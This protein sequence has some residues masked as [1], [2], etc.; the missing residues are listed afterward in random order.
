M[1]PELKKWIAGAESWH[2]Y[3]DF[4]LQSESARY[5]FL[6]RTEDYYINLVG[7]VFK[8]L[9]ED[10]ISVAD[11]ES[12]RVLARALEIF[13]LKHTRSSFSG[14]D[15]RE[16]VLISAAMYRVAGYPASSTFLLNQYKNSDFQI[17]TDQLL[18]RLLS[19]DLSGSIDDLSSK[20]KEYIF[21]GD[22]SALQSLRHEIE[23]RF[24]GVGR[25]DPKSFLSLKLC[26]VLLCALEKDCIW[27]ILRAS[28]ALTEE[29]ISKFITGN[30]L[31]RSNPVWS[32]F[33][34]QITA[35]ESGVL[36]PQGAYALQMPTSAGKTALAEVII[37]SEGVRESRGKIIFLAP[38]RSLATELKNSFA[39][40]LRS[41]GIKVEVLYGD[42]LLCSSRIARISE[43]DLIISTPEKF[44]ALAG[45]LPTLFE[46]I[47]LAICDE[48]HL[49]DEGKR[50][51]HYELLLAR[52]K[53]NQEANVIFLSAVVPNID[54]INQWLGGDDDSVIKSGYKPT[55][56][57]YGFLRE[58][59]TRESFQL[60]MNPLDEYPQKYVLFDFLVEPELFPMNRNRTRPRNGWP[61]AVCS[62]AAAIKATSSGP[63][64]LFTPTIFDNQGVLVLARKCLQLLESHDLDIKGFTFERLDNESKISEYLK[65]VFGIDYLLVQLSFFGV[66][67]HCGILPQDVR[68][69]IEESLRENGIRLIICTKTLAEGVNL[70]IRTLLIH[71]LWITRGEND[72]RALRV[73][74]IKNIV[75]RAGRA[76]KEVKGTII[77]TNRRSE[78]VLL[79][80]I[81]G[82]AGESV[83][84]FLLK[85]VK[86]I[87]TAAGNDA[88]TQESAITKLSSD[89]VDALDLAILNMLSENADDEE[90]EN[91]ISKLIENSFANAQCTESQQE[92]L[93]RLFAVRKSAI[94][95]TFSDGSFAALK[96][97]GVGPNLYGDILFALDVNDERWTTA[98]DDFGGDI[99]D[100]LKHNVEQ[101]AAWHA[102]IERVLTKYPWITADHYWSII[103]GW[104][105]GE[106]YQTLATILNDDTPIKI[107]DV[108]H[109]LGDESVYKLKI[110]LDAIVNVA[111]HSLEQRNL[112]IAPNLKLFSVA[113]TFGLPSA[114][115]AHLANMGF[116]ERLSNLELGNFL[117]ENHQAFS[118]SLDQ[119]TV[120]AAVL[121]YDEDLVDRLR[122]K[123]PLLSLEKMR[124]GIESVKDDLF[125]ASLCT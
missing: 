66:A 72:R 18:Y 52:L 114:M 107:D 105:R 3:K 45:R 46:E 53:S 64:A 35:I 29:Q 79:S 88:D 108:L 80:V 31:K 24:D 86:A 91:T 16:N 117:K 26:S 76:G 36:N 95:Q 23:V 121:F 32:F 13:S 40:R 27:T 33:P 112:V 102:E 38:Y 4:D 78:N 9:S 17:D 37:Y 96:K 47:S 75:G 99:F 63:T 82:D 92:V 69:I 50:G 2:S 116:G 8:I 10:E 93:T 14:I 15:T 98:S 51:L 81:Q 118:D 42:D 74:D 71:N 124:E 43:C 59:S 11:K 119:D 58:N 113:L 94:E 111:S 49:L 48:G 41:T 22:V 123:L 61:K 12:L 21:R 125:R 110:M 109:V 28:G 55:P 87:I 89:V 68:E 122:D 85:I 83:Y 34:S 90:L 30:L 39:K 19:S 20:L 25:G 5:P 44:T 84:G 57:E 7:Q 70:P 54:E 65:S 115:H 101:L 62:A 103:R 1:L 56:L 77:C 67:Y 60:E 97:T 6:A 104:L 106:S 120:A 100:F 73:R